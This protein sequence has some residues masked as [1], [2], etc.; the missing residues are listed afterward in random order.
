MK[1]LI[2]VKQFLE[3]YL[4]SMTGASMFSIRQTP[5]QDGTIRGC[6]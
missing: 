1:L 5:K 3:I 2:Q 6:N 4:H